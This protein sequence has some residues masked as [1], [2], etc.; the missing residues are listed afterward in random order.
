MC[1][2]ASEASWSLKKKK[3]PKFKNRRL[4][5]NVIEIIH[6]IIYHIII[7]AY[8]KN[9]YHTIY[10]YRGLA[11]VAIVKMWIVATSRELCHDGI[12]HC[13]SCIW[14]QNI[15]ILFAENNFSPNALVAVLHHF[16]QAGQ[17]KRANAQ[18]RVYA[19]HAAGLYFLLLEIPGEQRVVPLYCWI[20][21]SSGK[22][23][24]LSFERIP[25]GTS[26]GFWAVCLIS[27]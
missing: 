7:K 16:V 5:F 22:I 24:L 9:T 23:S 14:P 2:N 17:H 4:Q 21:H 3:G 6:S 8:C 27:L 13:G 26:D 1:R 20:K 11:A 25:G 12:S 15:W 19:L 10:I 18:Q